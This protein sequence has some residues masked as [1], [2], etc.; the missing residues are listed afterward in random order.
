M[1]STAEALKP[2]LDHCEVNGLDVAEF[3]RQEHWEKEKHLKY[4][5]EE[6]GVVRWTLTKFM[7][8][9]GVGHRT[10]REAQL[11]SATR[12]SEKQRKQRE[13][14]KRAGWDL[15]RSEEGRRAASERSR[16]DKNPAKKPGVGARISAAKMGEKNWMYGRY[17][18]LNP[19]WRG[20]TYG[21]VEAFRRVRGDI[22]ERDNH[23]C[24]LCGEPGDNVHHI[25]YERLNN[26]P[27]N[28][29]TLCHKHHMGTNNGGENRASWQAYFENLMMET[30][31]AFQGAF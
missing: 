2:I 4:M 15:A 25:N 30:G 10:L 7:D 24:Q 3:L 21:Y 6:W 8:K 28:L 11:L 13:Q 31:Y 5:A 18:P 16:G 26:D 27:G 20:G 23:T 9:I 29:V 1:T 14:W 22:L 12:P 17:G 19:S